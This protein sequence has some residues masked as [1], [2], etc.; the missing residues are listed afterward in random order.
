[1][2]EIW[3]M[4]SVAGE[5]IHNCPP[6]FS[7]FVPFS[8]AGERYSV[9][10]LLVPSDQVLLVMVRLV[11]LPFTVMEAS[12]IRFF[13]DK[14]WSTLLRTEPSLGLPKLNNKKQIM[15]IADLFIFHLF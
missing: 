9:N 1:L 6:S 10:D 14:F 13:E 3:M 7:I 2:P 8:D 11:R 12:V 5:Y 15:M 4:R